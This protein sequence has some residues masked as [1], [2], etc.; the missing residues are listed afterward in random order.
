LSERTAPLTRR[1]RGDLAHARRGCLKQKIVYQGMR[2]IAEETAYSWLL[3]DTGAKP[4]VAAR[5]HYRSPGSQRRNH[6]TCR[7]RNFCLILD[8]F[9]VG[10]LASAACCFVVGRNVR[11]HS[12]I[13]LCAAYRFR[14]RAL[15]RFSFQPSL[16]IVGCRSLRCRV[17]NMDYPQSIHRRRGKWHSAGGCGRAVHGR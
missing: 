14:V 8:S 1:R 9:G 11:R 17:G 10:Q 6:E 7:K 2:S 3:A 13:Q 4:P 15:P 5:T 12:R 16:G